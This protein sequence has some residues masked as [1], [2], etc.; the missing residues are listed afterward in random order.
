VRVLKLKRLIGLLALPLMLFNHAEARGEIARVSTNMGE[1]DLQL[2]AESA[3]QTVENFLGY[4]RRG[5]YN[6]SFIHRS[7]PGFVIQGGGFRL[8]K[9]AVDAV[10]A[11]P[12]VVNEPGPSNVRGTVAMAKVGGN[13]DSATNQWFVN[14]SNSNAANLDNQNGGFTV[15]GEVLG[16]G[17]AVADAIAALPVYDATRELGPVFE[18]LPL[19]QPRLTADNLVLFQTV[20]DLG[21]G[22]RVFSFDFSKG[23]HGFAP[24]FADLP[25]DYDP[26]LY[27]LQSGHGA[28]PGEIGGGP[29][30]FISGAN[31]SDDLWMYWRKKISGLAP[32]TVYEATFDLQVASSAAAG[33]VGIGG[34]PGESVF[35]KAGASALEPL[36]SAD[37]SGWLRMNV[38]KGNQSQSGAAASVLGNAAKPDDGT[39]KFAILHRDNRTSRLKVRSAADGSLWLFF[40][41]DSGFEGTTL[42]HY[43][44]FTAVFEPAE[45]NQTISFSPPATVKFGTAF[46]ANA[47]ASSGLP[48]T[49]VSS[50]ASVARVA[51][52]RIQIVGTGTTR[53]TAS[54]QG[55]MH[56]NAASPVVRTVTVVKGDQKIVFA[57]PGNKKF[58]K[59]AKFTLAATVNSKLPITFTS[60]NPSVVSIQGRTATIRGRGEVRITARQGGNKNWNAAP[61]V[62]R[63]FR[64]R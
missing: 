50:N 53:I 56:W 60:S 5:D 34:A 21:S 7:V 18:E 58:R 36:A 63:P 6:N 39:S 52:G 32:G 49:L 44:K 13:P 33:L 47:T 14:L 31:R 1:F 22:A 37:K 27:D 2:F 62:G 10:P 20:R 38:D 35:L 23:Q 24:G 54:Q 29:A 41:S 9:N 19:R 43:L 64:I 57:N 25:A 48:V 8:N 4:V 61:A 46:S 12:A 3:P 26:V 45:A 59:G 55:D 11:G 28:A 16:N 51:D 42:L 30:L 15:F 17:M 40:G